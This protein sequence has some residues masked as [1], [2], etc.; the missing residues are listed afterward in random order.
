MLSQRVWNALMTPLERE[1]LLCFA[2]AEKRLGRRL[3]IQDLPD[4]IK[5][6]L[7]WGIPALKRYLAKSIEP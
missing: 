7:L 1:H 3:V 5:A 2:C 6:N 4:T